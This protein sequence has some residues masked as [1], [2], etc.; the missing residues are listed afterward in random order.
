MG[1]KIARAG[2]AR[3]RRSCR[4]TD[5]VD[6]SAVGAELVFARFFDFRR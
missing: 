6:F 5:G 1:A 2:H 3:K 4:T